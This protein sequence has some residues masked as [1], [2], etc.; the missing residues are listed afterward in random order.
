MNNKIIAGIKDFGNKSIMKAQKHSPEILLI[1]GIIGVIGST[2]LA[3]R[4]T[5]KAKDILVESKKNLDNIHEKAAS[6]LIEDYTKK[7]IKKETAMVYVKTTGKLL[8]EYAPSIIIGGLSLTGIIASHG[9]LKN[10]NVAI[11]AA[12]ATIDKSFKEYKSRVIDKVGEGVEREI[13]YGIKPKDST[14]EQKEGDINTPENIH[15]AVCNGDTTAS[16]YARFFDKYTKNDKGEIVINTAWEDS[17]EY[18]LVFLKAQQS[19]ANDLLRVKKRLF[20]NEVYS[21]L[22]IPETKAGQVVGWVYNK[23]NPKGDTFIDFGIYK[24]ADNFTDFINGHDPILL[25]FNP[26]GNI[27]DLM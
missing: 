7:D 12:Y 18:N 21:M 5:L 23:D 9:V 17:P 22:G 14:T 16:P 24:Y 15:K 19:Y 1:T 13:R 6:K 27:W 2:I 8:K 26:Q 20:L 4:A 3:C 11:A 25:D 10:R